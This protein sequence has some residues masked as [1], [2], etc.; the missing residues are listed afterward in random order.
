VKGH[1]RDTKG[2]SVGQIG[3]TGIAPVGCQI[4]RRLPIAVHVTLQQWHQAGAVGRVAVFDHDIE[5]QATGTARERQLMAILH[6]PLAFDD[7]VGMGLEQ[8]DDLLRRGD[9]FAGENAP[10]SLRNDRQDQWSV[11]LHPGAPGLRMRLFFQDF[12]RRVQIRQGI[13]R[14]L[15]Q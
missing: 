9:A 15:Q 13:G 3:T 4:A 1:V 6:L 2:F 8:T 10:L 12:V 11:V 7:D 5:N 14:H